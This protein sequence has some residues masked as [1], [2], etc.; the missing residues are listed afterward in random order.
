MDTRPDV[1]RLWAAFALLG[2]GLVHLAVVSE[3]LEESALHGSF[4][5][6]V[7]TAQLGWG[8]LAMART[9]VPA[10]RALVAVQ[11]AIV[12]IWAASRT[13]GLPVPPERWTT[14][15]V[16]TADLLAVA[17]EAV[18]VTATVLA[19]RVVRASRPATPD[20]TISS[21]RLLAGAAAGALLV[22]VLTTPALA[23]TEAGE[24]AH[25]HGEHGATAH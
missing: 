21:R 25:P 2:A 1:L 8:V 9:T 24:H 4:F 15:P 19:A 11:V 22:S 5:V 20:R 18:A 17:L 13:V 23:A 10:P 6:V 14:E 7:G 12:A 3:H 16:G